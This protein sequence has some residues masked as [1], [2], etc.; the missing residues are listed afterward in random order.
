MTEDGRRM[1]DDGIQNSKSRR[2]NKNW[3]FD[4]DCGIA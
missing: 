1:T 4:V 2:E 3:L